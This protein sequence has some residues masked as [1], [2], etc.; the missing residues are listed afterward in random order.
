M[1]KAGVLIFIFCAVST[2]GVFVA[3]SH[4]GGPKKPE[5]VM[6]FDVTGKA[7]VTQVVCYFGKWNNQPALW[8]QA[9]VKNI[10][11]K[12]VQYKT[13]CTLHDIGVNRGFW[14]PK[15]G[16]PLVKPG[17]EGKAKFPFTYT[18]LPQKVTIVVDDVPGME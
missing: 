10:T 1:K 4:A 12:P 11:D 9:K 7:Q 18:K 8:I 2:F 6:E 16:N 17:K 5:M 14:V 15:A 13:R 3:E